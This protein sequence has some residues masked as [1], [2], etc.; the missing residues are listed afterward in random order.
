[1]LEDALR[2]SYGVMTTAS[3]IIERQIGHSYT[4]K[5]VEKRV[6]RSSRLQEVRR[7]VEE[8]LLDLAENKM[9]EAIQAGDGR[10]VRWLLG[11]KGAHRGYRHALALSNSDGTVLQPGGVTNNVLVILP[12]NGR[13]PDLA[14]VVQHVLLPVPPRQPA[15][16]TSSLAADP[17]QQ[18]DL[19]VE[20]GDD[21]GG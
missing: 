11:L 12:D 9:V 20:G 7:Q 18:L 21:E 14:Q 6:K 10:T 19:F 3:G 16:L 13:D 17:E 4:R 8:E 5:A 1:M 15:V 2:R